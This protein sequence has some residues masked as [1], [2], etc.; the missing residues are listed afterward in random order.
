MGPQR[1]VPSAD[2]SI[3]PNN[4][5]SLGRS[6]SALTERAINARSLTRHPSGDHQHW[7]VPGVADSAPI[8]SGSPPIAVTSRGWATLHLCRSFTRDG[9]NPPRC[10]PAELL[11]AERNSFELPAP[12]GSGQRC[13]RAAEADRRRHL[14]RDQQPTPALAAWPHLAHHATHRG[15][16]SRLG[17]DNAIDRVAARCRR[18]RSL[19]QPT[20]APHGGSIRPAFAGSCMPPARISCRHTT[21]SGGNPNAGSTPRRRWC[22]PT[23]NRG[24]PDESTLPHYLPHPRR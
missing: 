10:A 18:W 17:V 5:S 22:E 15:T 3:S 8:R 11:H 23:V 7:C 14:R 4:A 20:M 2:G 1:F 13:R 16:A 24:K 6:S 19:I 9:P 12:T 21:T